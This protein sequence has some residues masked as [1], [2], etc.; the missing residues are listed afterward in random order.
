METQEEDLSLT[1]Y[2]NL[3]SKSWYQRLQLGSL[4]NSNDGMATKTSLE[5]KHLGCGDYFVIITVII[6]APLLL[7]KQVA[8]RL[9]EAP[10]NKPLSKIP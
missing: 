8:N 1:V 4:I 10:L 2:E 3:V 7:T 5:N 9:V 6:L